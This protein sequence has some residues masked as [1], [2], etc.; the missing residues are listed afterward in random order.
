MRT[1]KAEDAPLVFYWGNWKQR[2]HSR[3]TGCEGEENGRETDV[4]GI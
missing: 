2:R 4:P 3:E 1:I